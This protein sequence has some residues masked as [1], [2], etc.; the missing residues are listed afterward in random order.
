MT[1]FPCSPR[2]GGSDL[3]PLLT[4]TCF[5]AHHDLFPLLTTTCFPCSPRSVSPL[6][7]TCFPAHHDL[8]PLLTTTCFPC[9]PRPVS[10][11]HHDLFPLLTTTCFPCSPRPVSPAHHDLFPCS[12]RG[13]GSRTLSRIYFYHFIIKILVFKMQNYLY[14]KNTV[15]F[16]ITGS[17]LK[18]I[19]F[20]YCSLV[21]SPFSY[22]IFSSFF[23]LVLSFS[24]SPKGILFLAT[25][26]FK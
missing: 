4:T 2:G 18:A 20:T 1:W 7:T 26:I 11:A 23:C 9:S 25:R 14:I 22:F 5:P 10:P 16:Y 3:F 6:T 21:S 24:F 17:A 8:F 19:R 13:G 12:P 15:F